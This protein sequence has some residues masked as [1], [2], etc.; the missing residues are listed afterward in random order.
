VTS[1]P[2]FTCPLRFLRV[3]YRVDHPPIT[4]SGFLFFWSLTRFG[5]CFVSIISVG[6]CCPTASGVYLDCCD[7]V[8]Q[9]DFEG[10]VSKDYALAAVGLE[11]EAVPAAATASTSSSIVILQSVSGL[12]LLWLTSFVLDTVGL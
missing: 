5:L 7:R 11:E 1:C 9:T 4:Y 8:Y 10:V 12:Y 3:L 6:T 2:V